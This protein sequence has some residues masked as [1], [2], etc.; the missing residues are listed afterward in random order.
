MPESVPT[1][2]HMTSAAV[3]QMELKEPNWTPMVS[4]YWAA[5]A[6]SVVAGGCKGSVVVGGQARRRRL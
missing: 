5:Y 4:A 6:S 3:S 2:G 1:S